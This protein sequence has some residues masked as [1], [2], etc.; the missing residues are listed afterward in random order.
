MLGSGPGAVKAKLAPV[1]VLVGLA[2]V[3][4]CFWRGYPDR[5]R[6]HADVLVAIA[7]KAGDLVAARRFTAESLPEL[8]YPLERATAFAAAARRRSSAPPPSLEAF[9]RLLGR[10]RTFVDL[11]DQ[12]RRAGADAQAVLAAPLR[13]VEEAA[14]GVTAALAAEHAT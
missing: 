9:E 2:V 13:D 11:V 3:A 1:A 14:A 5:I 10:Y 4:G 12:T 6:T 8:T 7:R